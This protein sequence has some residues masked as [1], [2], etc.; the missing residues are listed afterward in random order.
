VADAEESDG[1]AEDDDPRGRPLSLA[2]AIPPVRWPL[3][4]L[5]GAGCG[6]GAAW[7]WA[8]S[9]PSWVAVVAS[10]AAA[11]WLV[12]AVMGLALGRGRRAEPSA[13]DVTMDVK[14]RRG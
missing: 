7:A 9:W 5:A 6:A 4:L 2:E 14:D 1:F 11:A 13:A 8:A 3:S 12:F 10:L